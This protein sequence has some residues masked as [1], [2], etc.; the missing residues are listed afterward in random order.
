M[1]QMDQEAAHLM[2]GLGRRKIMHVTNGNGS[3]ICVWYRLFPII[4][5]YL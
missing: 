1:I 4:T 3:N 5:I 2:S